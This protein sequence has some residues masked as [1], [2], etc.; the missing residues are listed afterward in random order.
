MTLKDD[1]E[2]ARSTHDIRSVL[3]LSDNKRVIVCPLPGHTHV[4]N[5]PS[6]SIYWRKGLQWWKCHGSC[7]R[8]GDVVDLVG[9]LRVPGYNPRDPDK[10]RE[11]LGLLDSRYEVKLVI[12]EKTIRLAGDEWMNFIPPSREVVEYAHTRGIT[13]ASIKKFRIGQKDSYMAIPAFQDGRLMGIKFRSFRDCTKARRFWSQAGSI[14]TLFNW[15]KIYLETGTVF[16]V[17]GEIP[18]MIID[19]MG[20]NVCAPT[21][22][23]G[24]YLDSWRTALALANVVVIGDNDAPG[25]VL[26][27]TRAKFFTAKLVFPPE[28]FQD[29]D[30]Y[31]L[32]DPEAAAETLRKWSEE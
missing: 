10:V 11:A 24:S 3:G 32:A 30:K 23:E 26:G 21:G 22:G 20:F 29:I 12:P 14:K 2:T 19:Q 25:R 9:Y 7:Q 28:E 1:L 6:F 15:D 18:A 8:E 16:V 4:S 27:D 31:I 17:K 5:T 13:D